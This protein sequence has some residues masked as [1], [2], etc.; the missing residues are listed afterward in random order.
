MFDNYIRVGLS[1][2]VVCRHLACDSVLSQGQAVI[3]LRCSSNAFLFETTR[4]PC[5]LSPL[6]TTWGF[7]KIILQFPLEIIKLFLAVDFTGTISLLSRKRVEINQ[8]SHLEQQ[9]PTLQLSCVDCQ[10]TYTH[11][12]LDWLLTV[13]NSSLTIKGFYFKLEIIQISAVK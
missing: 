1:A 9:V 7:Y 10:Y 4:A 6:V 13:H 3:V 12:C 8:P 11:L 5:V 2:D